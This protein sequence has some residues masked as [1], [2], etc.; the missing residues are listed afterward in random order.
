M[1]ALPYSSVCITGVGYP[2]Y[3]MPASDYHEMKAGKYTLYMPNAD[4]PG[5]CMAST[6]SCPPAGAEGAVADATKIIAIPDAPF[7]IRDSTQ[8][9]WPLYATKY[10][11]E[12][13]SPKGASHSHQYTASDGAK[14]TF[15]MPN[16]VTMHQEAQCDGSVSDQSGVLTTAAQDNAVL[17]GAIVGGVGGF[18]LLVIVGALVWRRNKSRKGG[19]RA[20]AAKETNTVA[21]ANA[22]AP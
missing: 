20:V 1:S 11:A 2:L 12:K 10:L 14:Y 17:I 16:G 21:D 4:V 13:A 22:A 8:A 9:T 18:L 6:C 5:K 19:K 15:Y 3:K 7:C